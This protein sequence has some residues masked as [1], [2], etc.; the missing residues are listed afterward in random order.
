MNKTDSF[1]P[2]ISIIAGDFNWKRSKLYSFDAKDDIVKE[3]D[4]IT[5]TAGYNQRIDIPTHFT[6]RSSSC[7]DL[8]FT[9]DPNIIVNSDIEKSLC[10]SCHHDITYGKNS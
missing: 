10:S 9:S 3:L 1:N 6:N 5:S 8:I 7:I 2:A 4:T